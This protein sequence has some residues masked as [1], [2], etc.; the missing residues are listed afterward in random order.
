ML[1]VPALLLLLL[2]P[3]R[4]LG[5]GPAAAGAAL[6]LQVLCQTHQT[7]HHQTQLLMLQLM[8]AQSHLPTGSLLTGYA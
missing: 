5:S 1:G 7:P 2:R 8:Q 4:G 3:L 6:L